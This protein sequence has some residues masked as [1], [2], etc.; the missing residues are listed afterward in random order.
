[1]TLAGLPPA[2][3][4]YI[5]SLQPAAWYQF[6]GV[7]SSVGATTFTWADAS[8]NART[9]NAVSTARPTLA[10]DG[11]VLFD[12]TASVMGTSFTLAPPATAYIFF[13]Q[14]T[15]TAGDVIFDGAPAASIACLAQLGTT[16]NMAAGSATTL[17]AIST[18][19]LSA[20]GALA[21]RW[22]LADSLVKNVIYPRYFDV[23]PGQTSVTSIGGVTLGGDGSGASFANVSIKEFMIFP[24]AH[25]IATINRVLRYLNYLRP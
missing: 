15:W 22:N 13:K 19:S 12:G 4:G 5:A 6:G 7:T 2:T 25:N 24:V 3:K 23:I 14:V 17:A 18:Q 10:S 11:S 21:V 20:Y 1:M 16:P 9:L 8:G